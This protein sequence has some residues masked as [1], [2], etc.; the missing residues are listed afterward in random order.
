MVQA[1]VSPACLA[2]ALL[3][4]P[5]LVSSAIWINVWLG[6]QPAPTLQVPEPIGTA[7]HFFINLVVGGA[8]GE[9]PGWRGYALLRWRRRQIPIVVI[10]CAAPTGNKA[11]HP[12]HHFSISTSLAVIGASGQA[13]NGYSTL[14]LAEAARRSV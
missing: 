13:P 5:T 7:L 4:P 1:R 6:N 3:L 8:L 9:E 11:K 2:V 14:W 10:R 12:M